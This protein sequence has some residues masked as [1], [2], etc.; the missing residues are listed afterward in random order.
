[1]TLIDM[2]IDRPANPVDDIEQ[3][4]MSNDWTFE[5]STEDEITISVAGHWC[6]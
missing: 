6:E 4:A 2:D 1:M 3:I 5:R